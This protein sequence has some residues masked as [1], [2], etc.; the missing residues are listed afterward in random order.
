MRGHATGVPRAGLVC[1]SFALSFLLSAMAPRA[2]SAAIRTVNAGGD[3]QA[4]LNAAQPGDEVVL[5]A[6][7]RFTGMFQ[8]PVKPF[9]AVITIRSSAPLPARRMTPADAPLLPLLLSG[10]GD[11]ALVGGRGVANWRLDG[12]QFGSTSSGSGEIIRIDGASSI[13]MDRLLMVAGPLGQKRGIQGNGTNITL[14][15]SHVANIW[16]AG[17]DS[18][19]FCAWDGAG[20]YTVTDNYL[21]AASENVMFGG[22]NSLAP[23]RVPADILVEGNHFSKRL[24]WRGQRKAVKNL[25]EL[26]SAKRVTVRNNLFEHNWTDAQ[27][28]TAIVFTVRN[29]EGGAPWSVIEDVLFEK[30]I[31]RDTEGIFNVLGYNNGDPSGRTTRITIKDNL[32]IGTGFFLLVGGEVGT[33]TLDHNTVDQGG[34]FVTLYTGEVWPAGTAGPR[35]AQFAVESLTITN[36]LANHNA[37]GVF[38]ENAGIGTAALAALTRS[39]RWTNNVLAGGT[40]R[41]YPAI[42]WLPTVADYRAQL[43]A[44]YALVASS[45]YRGAGSDGRDLGASMA[46]LSTMVPSAP[47]GVRTT[48][49]GF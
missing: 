28:G 48:R 43:T 8:L 41:A 44:D 26:K 24:E 10:T 34:N 22:A 38:G 46:V 32:A 23:D 21:E 5:A 25:F 16:R 3:L 27:S 7:A 45:P 11:P 9:G 1:L 29:D 6:G 31:I 33:L 37:Y 20:P 39:Y 13:Y 49:I 40:G 36:M 19:A 18:Q 12:L 42:T 30:N 17:Q 47:R 4:A 2:A 15:R 35:L 14:T